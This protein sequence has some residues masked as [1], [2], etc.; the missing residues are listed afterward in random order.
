MAI[1]VVFRVL[2]CA[3]LL[4]AVLS[5]EVVQPDI[6]QVPHEA[7]E[8]PDITAS[9]IGANGLCCPPPD[10]NA[11]DVSGQGVIQISADIAQLNVAI[12]AKYV[13]D[14]PI[15][16]GLGSLESSNRSLL[17]SLVM[18][19]VGNLT[20]SVLDYLRKINMSLN[21]KPKIPIIQLLT[22][23]IQLTQVYRYDT[24]SSQQFLIGYNAVNSLSITLNVQDAS[25]VLAGVLD[26]GVTRVDSV[27]LIASANAIALGRQQAISLAAADAIKQTDSVLAT[28]LANRRY[29]KN[30]V[31][32]RVTD[33]TAPGAT[34]VSSN[35]GEGLNVMTAKTASTI[36]PPVLSGKKLVFAQVMLRSKFSLL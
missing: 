27:D 22:T 10:N 14:S 28:I 2:L 32:L 15:S 1:A 16:Q 12:E 18:S 25:T 3:L 17:G 11:V 29:N 31:S 34:S 8:L 24:I 21:G 33:V 30:I 4:T 20:I 9:I 35:S 7:R 23:G 19:R 36:A 13:S 6:A 5:N 26:A